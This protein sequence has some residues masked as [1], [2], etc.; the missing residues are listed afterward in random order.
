MKKESSWPA[1][2]IRASRKVWLS[3]LP[4][5]ED[6]EYVRCGRGGEYDSDDDG[7]LSE[8]GYTPYEDFLKDS[9]MWTVDFLEYKAAEQEETKKEAAKKAIAADEANT[10]CVNEEQSI[11]GTPEIHAKA[12]VP[13]LSDVAKELADA[14]ASCVSNK[15][16][17]GHGA[18]DGD[19]LR[20]AAGDTELLLKCPECKVT[21][22][23]RIELDGH[24]IVHIGTDSDAV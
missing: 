21:F 3:F 13:S 17:D 12:S 2:A 9:D 14:L 22:S 8:E 18:Q 7:G 20:S 4:Y 10:K 15:P 5:P 6:K 1:F 24:A 23:S 19:E 11:V 16:E